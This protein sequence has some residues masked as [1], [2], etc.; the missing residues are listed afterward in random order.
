VLFTSLDFLILFLP[1]TL[2][3]ALRLRG[4]ALLRW[5]ALASIVF[6]GFAGHWW[7]ILPMLVTTVV[8][9]WVARWLEGAGGAGCWPCRWPATWGCWL[10][11][12]TPAC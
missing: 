2:A 3:M 4:Q 6:Y 8:D 11:S 10:G 9:Y 5:I 12:S 1:V 7:F